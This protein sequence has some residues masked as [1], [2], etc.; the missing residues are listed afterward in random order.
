[1]WNLDFRNSY[2]T[3]KL[4]ELEH[5][6][7]EEEIF[8]RRIKQLYISLENNNDLFAQ[9]GELICTAEK[10]KEYNNILEECMKNI[11]E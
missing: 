6:M 10:L 9:N 3:K 11:E 7:T 8:I 4:Q 1:M 2:V 5:T